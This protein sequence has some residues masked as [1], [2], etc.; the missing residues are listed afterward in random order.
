MME[1]GVQTVKPQPKVWTY[2]SYPLGVATASSLWSW[3]LEALTVRCRI[4]KHEIMEKLG[5]GEQTLGKPIRHH[6]HHFHH[7]IKFHPI[8]FTRHQ[9][10]PHLPGM[11]SPGP[12]CQ[13]HHWL[14]GTHQAYSG[15]TWGEESARE[16]PQART[17]VRHSGDPTKKKK[18]TIGVH[19]IIM[20]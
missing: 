19:G 20:V 5:K 11:S 6:Y 18:E 16:S 14:S 10:Y 12:C 3:R 17:N 2:P 8:F 1:V 7:F 15:P 9:A 13:K 4:S